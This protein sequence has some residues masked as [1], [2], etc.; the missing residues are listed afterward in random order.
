MENIVTEKKNH[1]RI[2]HLL[3][4]LNSGLYGKEEAVRLALLSAVAGESI[5]FLGPPGTAKSMISRRI[6]DAFKD[7]TTYFEYLLNEF[8]TPD[9]ICGPVSL[10]GLEDDEYKRITKG[11][12]PYSC[13]GN[14][15]TG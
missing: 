6:K 10:K 11:C 13:S 2:D 4:F 14:S 9:E 8:S 15:Y 5:F 7:E 1:D 12:L 3:R